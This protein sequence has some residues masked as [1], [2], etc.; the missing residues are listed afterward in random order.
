[1]ITDNDAPQSV[2][3]LWTS[4]RLVAET[5]TWQNPT[6]TTDIHVPSKIRT[7]GRNRRAAVDL[8]LRPPG[9]WGRLRNIDSH[10]KFTVT[11]RRRA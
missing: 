3:L 5:S 11:S 8:H 6:H 7:H 2:G 1:L 10:F 9:H 4:D